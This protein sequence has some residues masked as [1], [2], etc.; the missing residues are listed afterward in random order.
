MSNLT[1]F[2]VLYLLA[3]IAI[4]LVAAPRVHNSQRFRG[5][6]PAP[7]AAAGDG[8]R[9]RDLVR[10]GDRARHLRHLREGRPAGRRGRP[11]RREPVPDSCGTLLRAA[12]LPP[13]SPHHR[14]LLPDALQ[15]R[16]RGAVH[17]RD[18]RLLPRLGLGADQGAGPGVSRRHGR[19]GEPAARDDDRRR[20]GPH[21]HHARRHA[22]GGG[23][24]L[25]ADDGDH[26]RHAL[27]RLGDLRHDGRRRRGRSPTPTR[28][29]S[30]TFS[31]RQSS[32]PGYRSSARG[33]R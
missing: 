22:V 4:G 24:R 16:G 9:V 28:P 18:R 6:G 17:A 5:R 2:V 27:H 8:D 1:V 21:L 26:G 25:R 10:G 32:P 30:S 29:A 33:S 13:E 7:A 12:A 19:R 11:V 14:R 20:H 23:A 15:P 31:R 3:S